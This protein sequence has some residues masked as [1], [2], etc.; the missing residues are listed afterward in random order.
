ML[1]EKKYD[2]ILVILRE[3]FPGRLLLSVEELAAVSGYKKQ[4]IYNGI[5]PKSSRPFFIAPV[6]PSGKPLF[7]INDIARSLSELT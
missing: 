4:T 6:R 1:K 3:Q 5:C 7:R 2:E